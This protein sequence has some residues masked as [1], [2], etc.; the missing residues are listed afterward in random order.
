M[1]AMRWFG[2]LAL[3]CAAAL[4]GRA[5]A[6]GEVPAGAPEIVSIKKI[7]D[8]APH[9]SFTDLIRFK[10]RWFLTFRE[11]LAHVGGDGKIR[12]LSSADGETWE[13]AALLEEK[14]VDLRDPKLS[15]TPE[16][17]LMLLMGGSIYKGTT[18]L[19]GR[20]S[21]VAFS[22]DGREWT[23]PKPILKEGDW[24]WRVTWHDG[25]GYG[26]SYN[27][28]TLIAAKAKAA[29]AKAGA[30][31]KSTRPENDL[32][33]YRT[34]DGVNYELVTRFKIDGAPNE[35]TARVL[36]NGEMLM[37]VRREGSAVNPD[38][39]GWV[40]RSRA[41]FTEW[42]WEASNLRF[43][44]QNF[45]QTPSGAVWVGTRHYLPAGAKTILARLE[46]ATL[47]PALTLPSGGDTSYPGMVWHEGLL[48]FSYYASHEG[49]S[50][51]YLA[52]IKLPGE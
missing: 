8:K 28:K 48:W 5:R 39:M 31:A 13:P 44:G 51:I 34:K 50:S 26:T 37:L 40:G 35:A 20:R 15:V 33:L 14:G 6:A 42:K 25:V 16:G 32:E 4:G 45:I 41:P 3:C 52:K 21:R 18:T 11:S 10:D 7:W 47:T 23:A 24:L 27:G 29:K 19:K 46:G 49:K 22:P 17:K 36:A 9:N 30:K 43:G 2:M 12:V 38:T 1:K